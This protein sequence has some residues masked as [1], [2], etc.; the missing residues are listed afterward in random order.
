MLH[1]YIYLWGVIAGVVRRE[2]TINVEHHGEVVAQ[3]V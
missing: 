3:E 1:I 2:S